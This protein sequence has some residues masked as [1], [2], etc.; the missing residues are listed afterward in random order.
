MDVY[1][2]CLL[3]QHALQWVN[4]MAICVTRSRMRIGIATVLSCLGAVAVALFGSMCVVAVLIEAFP[5]IITF[6]M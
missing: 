5:S 4:L 6:T 3:R 1:C 2:P